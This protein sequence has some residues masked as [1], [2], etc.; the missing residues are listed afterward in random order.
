MADAGT[1]ATDDIIEELEKQL[2]QEYSR[3][4]KETT[5]KLDDYLRRFQIKD[6]IKRKALQEGKIT[7]EYYQYWRTGQI[8]IGERWKEMANTL[9]TDLANVDAIAR[10]TVKGYMMDVYALNHGYATFEIE[11]DTLLDTS[12]TLYNRDTVQNLWKNNPKLLPDPVPGSP[13][14][15]MLE[16]HEDMRWNRDNLQAELVQGIL[17]GESIPQL[18]ARMQNVTDMDERSAVRNARTMCTGAMNKGRLDGYQRAK[19][20]GIEVKKVWSA[21]HDG[22]TRKSHAAQD[23]EAVELDKEF[24][25]GC[26]YPGDPDADPSEVYNCRCSMN[27]ESER[28]KHSYY[29]QDLWA[30][31]KK[32]EDIVP[33][34]EWVEKKEQQAQGVSRVIR[35][36]IGKTGN[37]FDAMRI[38]YA[39]AM[40]ERAPEALQKAWAD[41]VED[42]FQ[43]SVGTRGD[44]YYQP[45]DNTVHYNHK[46]VANGDSIHAP[47]ENYFHEYGHNLDF[48]LSNDNPDAWKMQAISEQAYSRQTGYNMSQTVIKETQQFLASRLDNDEYIN[49]IEQFLNRCVMD[50]NITAQTSA[51]MNKWA[52]LQGI[53][54]KSDEYKALLS[55]RNL[56]IKQFKKTP[57]DA[58]YEQ[59][60]NFFMKNKDIFAPQ[61][62][63]RDDLWVLV[64][65]FESETDGK[66]RTFSNMSD[67]MGY[68]T[69]KLFNDAYPMGAGHKPSYWRSSYGFGHVGKEAFAE[70]TASYTANRES[71]ELIEKF[72][73]ETLKLYN[74]ILEGDYEI[75]H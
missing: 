66:P 13:T 4:A 23:G 8:L 67:M 28:S 18:A 22:R 30:S 60:Y 32:G 36:Y 20:M 31:M 16:E 70:I 29:M 19:D 64:A 26:M 27:C 21:T 57:D 59:M 7:K 73:P 1:K 49:R 46:K 47:M 61:F 56:A 69:L 9:A 17:Q 43:E 71:L 2:H 14:A 40:M 45:W 53:D 75:R 62:M 51:L 72:Y 65:Q 38:K 35:D 44:A 41:G 33:Y 74:Q 24:P 58:A 12:Y 3:A 6:E 10:S 55:E 37:G 42:Y 68:T 11:R 50:E 5:A 54:K 48:K 39:Q 63:E 25:N 34:Q 52:T 15:K